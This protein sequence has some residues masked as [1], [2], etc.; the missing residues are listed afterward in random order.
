VHEFVTINT[1][2]NARFN[3]EIYLAY[4]EF[5]CLQLQFVYFKYNSPCQNKKQC[6]SP[7]KYRIHDYMTLS[8]WTSA[9]ICNFPSVF[10]KSDV[11]QGHTSS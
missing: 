6:Y 4:V 5:K 3:Y 7:P 11:C 2:I 9:A 10:D 1:D 8:C